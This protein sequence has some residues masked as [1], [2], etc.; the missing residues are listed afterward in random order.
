MKDKII[1]WLINLWNN[2]KRIIVYFAFF[3]L[4]LAL[5]YISG[6][7]HGKRLVHCPQITSNTVYVHDTV[8]H[9]ITN[10]FP[11]YVY[12]V[13]TV[14]YD[15]LIP[16]DVDTA[17]ILRN[18]F[19]TY[20]YERYWT[21]RDTLEVF[22]T[23]Y[24]S[25]NKPIHNIFKYKWLLPTTITNTTVDNSVTYSSYLYIGGSVPISI[26]NFK[27][28]S[29]DLTLALPKWYVGVGYLPGVNTFAI[30]GGVKIFQFKK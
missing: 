23:D 22:L 19:A 2:N 26:G 12:K 20:K 5:S 8:F 18:F 1:L 11:Y 29:I 3:A 24:I 6:C 30:K 21:A 7:R 13:D 14:I 10:Q 25:Q 4:F 17:E 28:S 9:T 27:Y 16:A 15:H